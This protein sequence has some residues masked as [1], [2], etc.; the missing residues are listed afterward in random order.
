MYDTNDSEIKDPIP[1]ISYYPGAPYQSSSDIRPSPS[2]HLEIKEGGSNLA[3]YQAAEIDYQRRSRCPLCLSILVFILGS[4]MSG[5]LIMYTYRSWSQCIYLSGQLIIELI[6][7]F[8]NFFAMA[9]IYRGINRRRIEALSSAKLAMMIDVL[10]WI[11]ARIL[12]ITYVILCTKEDVQILTIGVHLIIPA[13]ILIYFWSESE[14]FQ[15]AIR[16]KYLPSIIF[17]NQ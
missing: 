16:C 5:S 2:L 9:Y 8:V 7:V 14:K 17:S 6:A 10:L 11:I 13:A 12:Y 3:L 1:I 4:F 15:K